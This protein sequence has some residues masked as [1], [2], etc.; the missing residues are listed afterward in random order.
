MSDSSGEEGALDGTFHAAADHLGQLVTANPTAVHDAVKLQLYGLYK[1][2]TAG[3]C[4]T[5]KPAFW[6]RA[7]RLKWWVACV[8]G[9][10]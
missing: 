3:K 6:D 9:A 8:G 4:S 7:A 5:P 1:Q 2:A 10:L